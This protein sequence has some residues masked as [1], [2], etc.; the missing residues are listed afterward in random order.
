MKISKEEVLHVA[1]L[2]RLSLSEEETEKL[3]ESMED[4]MRQLSISTHAKSRL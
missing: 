4:L 1:K 3:Q 2:A